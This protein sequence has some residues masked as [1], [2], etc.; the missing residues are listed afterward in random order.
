MMPRP[1][2]RG[3]GNMVRTVPVADLVE[4]LAQVRRELKVDAV[5]ILTGPRNW[6][7]MRRDP[8]FAKHSAWWPGD[9]ETFAG[10]S[11]VVSRWADVPRVM[12]TQQDLEAALL[13]DE[14]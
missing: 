10:V 6:T 12:A 2:A 9:E 3:P 4:D 11:V 1:K 13:G 5:A 7:Y 8:E 14:G